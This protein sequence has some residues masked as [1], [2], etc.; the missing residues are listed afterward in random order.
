MQPLETPKG[1]VSFR[2]ANFT[3]APKYRELRLFALKDSPTSFSADYYAS[4]NAPSSYWEGR[5][6]PGEGSIM[7]FAEH[8]GALIGMIG[9][10]RGDRPKTRHSAGIWGVYVLPEWRGLRIAASLIESCEIWAKSRKVEI[11]KLAVVTANQSA[12][13]CY[14]RC[15]FKTYGTDPRVLFYE[16]NYYDEFLMA[17]AVTK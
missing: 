17:K 7:F 4:L 2:P 13:R 16:G 15:G 10:Q 8:E 3:D 11:L 5:L 1:I 14:E 12:I 6:K 9:V